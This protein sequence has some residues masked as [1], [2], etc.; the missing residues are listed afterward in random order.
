MAIKKPNIKQKV[1]TPK[2]PYEIDINQLLLHSRQV[3]LTGEISPKVVQPVIAQI[4]GLQL[5]SDEPIVLWI[6]SPGGF[7]TDG[8]ALI[9]CIRMSKVPI[10][11]VIRGMAASM[12]GL[13]SL[14]GHQR[15]ITENSTFMAHD[16]H[17]GVWDYG[18]KLKARAENIEKNQN[19][20][21]SFLRNNSKLSEQDLEKARHEELWLDP[22]Q[23]LEKGV[24]D[25]VFTLERKK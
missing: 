6:N 22:Q 11:T 16:I 9:D 12:A 24:V 1:E 7:L 18:D 14:A 3:H 8:F 21:F 10:F 4:M 19:H 20:V 15:Y 13:I 2:L 23:C 17:A 5:V 25:F